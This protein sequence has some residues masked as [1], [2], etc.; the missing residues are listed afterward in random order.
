MVSSIVK[1]IFMLFFVVGFRIDLACR[2]ELLVNFLHISTKMK[3][4]V[5][6]LTDNIFT[7]DVSEDLELENFKAFCEMES[8][9]PA[10]EILINYNGKPLMDNSRSLKDH[11]LCDG[12]VVTLQRIVDSTTDRRIPSSRPA[13]SS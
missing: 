7:L 11:G 8:G 13:A 5:T 12:E 10:G 3:V 9:I 1:L 4:T 6:T 2:Y